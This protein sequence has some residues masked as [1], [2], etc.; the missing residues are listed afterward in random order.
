MIINRL[1]HFCFL[2]L[3]AT[4]IFAAFQLPDIKIWT[5]EEQLFNP[6][7]TIWEI[8]SQIKELRFS[9]P[10]V[11][12]YP[13][14]YNFHIIGRLGPSKISL[15]KLPLAND[16]SQGFLNSE[17]VDYQYINITAN[18]TMSLLERPLFWIGLM[19]CSWIILAAI[20]FFVI[21]ERVRVT[22]KAERIRVDIARDLH[23]EIGANVNSIGLL[24]NVLKNK[25]HALPSP[26]SAALVSDLD[27]IQENVTLTAQSLREKN[28]VFKP[29]ND[30]MHELLSRIE[31]FAY[32]ILPA[33]GINFFYKCHF[34]LDSRFNVG[35]KQ[36]EN[37][38]FMCKE[39]INNIAK[40]SNATNASIDVEKVVE[41]IRILIQDDGQGFDPNGDYD[42]DGLRNLHA[43]AKESKITLQW[44]TQPNKGTTLILIVPAL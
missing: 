32:R 2:Y 12:D 30:S 42:G 11:M 31:N 10:P 16:T 24:L 13:T 19:I 40:H 22:I 25:L 9:L 34:Q 8:T 41:G 33:Q 1:L 43:R 38:F 7:D 29:E 44:D 5:D 26:N 20:F 4:P 23:D 3:A 36:R 35:M 28:W 37:A 14:Q 18:I 21:A 15:Q 39:A 6:N 17:G 27:K